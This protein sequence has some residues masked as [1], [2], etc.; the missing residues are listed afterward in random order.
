MLACLSREIFLPCRFA[1]LQRCRFNPYPGTKATSAG[2]HNKA[3][4]VASSAS[5]TTSA[6]AV[7]VVADRRG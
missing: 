3:V 7:V 6:S 5:S 2:V 4:E 1:T